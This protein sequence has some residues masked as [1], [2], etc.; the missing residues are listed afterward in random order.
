MRAHSDDVKH[1]SNFWSF[2]IVFDPFS[3]VVALI[4]CHELLQSCFDDVEFLSPRADEISVITKVLK[5]NS[6]YNE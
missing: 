2:G 5:E 6:R 1:P 3:S 4:L